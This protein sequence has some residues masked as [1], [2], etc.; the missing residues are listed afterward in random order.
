FP[1]TL[2]R[3]SSSVG[4]SSSAPLG[5]FVSSSVGFSSPDSVGFSVSSSVGLAVPPSIGFSDSSSIGFWRSSSP[6]RFISTISS[7]ISVVTDSV[8]SLSPP[9]TSVGFESL[10][11]VNFIFLLVST[12][13]VDSVLGTSSCSSGAVDSLRL[14][15]IESSVICFSSS[16]GFSRESFRL[17]FLGFLFLHQLV[18]LH[19]LF[20]VSLFLH[21]FLSVCF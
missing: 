16:A 7:L 20:W 4:L 13:T 2:S 14:K 11:L 12:S 19:Q 18:S 6:D 5:F 15:S 3:V 17:I 21:H 9:S 1:I 8:L 10:R